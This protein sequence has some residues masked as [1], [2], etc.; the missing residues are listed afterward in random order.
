MN[1][2]AFGRCNETWQGRSESGSVYLAMVST[3]SVSSRTVRALKYAM[4]ASGCIGRS[5]FCLAISLSP[6]WSV[7]DSLPKVLCPLA[8]RDRT[9]RAMFATSVYDI[10]PLFL[11][12]ADVSHIT[13]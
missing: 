6:C 4:S 1:A 7:T 2:N 5:S 11:L 9:T 10:H 3:W 12:S 13:Y 8:Q